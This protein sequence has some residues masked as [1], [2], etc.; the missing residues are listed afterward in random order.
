ML[1]GVK[2]AQL[3]PKIGFLQKRNFRSDFAGVSGFSR[4]MLHKDPYYEQR[5]K[6]YTEPKK[7]AITVS[8]TGAAGH[9]GYALL[10]RIASGQMFGPNQPVYINAIELPFVL[11]KLRGVEM[12]LK[13]CAFPLLKGIKC[14]DK[15]EEGFANTNYAILV[16]SKPR[17]PN[18]ERSDLIKDNG[19]I[20]QGIGR[21]LN[22]HANTNCKVFVV[23][24]P[25]NTNCLICAHNAPDLDRKNF[26][27]MMRLD[28]D[29]GLA[30]AADKVGQDPQHLTEYFV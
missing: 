9:I 21:S 18:Q 30:M 5:V 28:H 23:G 16:G 15:Y 22:K 24:N 2:L 14:T 6:E 10:F 20:F 1:R 27:A 12:E 3:K 17:G 25:A 8:V 11:S 7:P 13:D 26:T 4:F 29:R 19:V